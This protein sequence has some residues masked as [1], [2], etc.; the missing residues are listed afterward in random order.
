MILYLVSYVFGCCHHFL[1]HPIASN[2]LPVQV[3]LR[4]KNKLLYKTGVW[5]I[6]KIKRGKQTEWNDSDD[7]DFFFFCNCAKS[8]NEC[9]SF[10]WDDDMNEIKKARRFTSNLNKVSPNNISIF[11]KHNFWSISPFPTLKLREQPWFH[12][13]MFPMSINN[14]VKLHKPK[15]QHILHDQSRR[16]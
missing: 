2:K 13:T 15:Y 7:N 10:L 14:L 5:W 9:V 8:R 1:K 11:P 6:N 4:K 16:A 12:V 3:Q